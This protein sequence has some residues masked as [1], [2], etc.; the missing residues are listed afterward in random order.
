M[1]GHTTVV[2]GK[3]K[4]IASGP[5]VVIDAGVEVGGGSGSLLEWLSWKKSKVHR[6][7]VRLE[8]TLWYWDSL[9]LMGG[10]RDR[11][12]IGQSR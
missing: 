3:F 10:P 4:V 9:G 5:K 8:E 7:N 1:A 11:H 2:C 12:C 6:A